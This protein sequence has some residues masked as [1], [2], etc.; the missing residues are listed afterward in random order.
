VAVLIP[1]SAFIALIGLNMINLPAF[2]KISFFKPVFVFA[3]VILVIRSSFAQWYFPFKPYNEEYVIKQI[4]TYIQTTRPNFKKVC[5]IHPSLPV[6]ADLDPYDNKRVELLHTTDLEHI[7]QLPDSTLLLW[8]SHFMK[9]DGKIPFNWLSENPNFIMLKHY[10]FS[11]EELPF[12]A[13][14]FIRAANPM[15]VP[16]PV[17]LV[18]PSGLILGNQTLETQI[19]TFE[20]DTLDFN[21]WLNLRTSFTGRNAV[22]FTP[23]MEF[24]P[25]FRK[26]IRDINKH[27]NLKSATLKFNLNQADTITDFVSV[28][29]IKDNKKQVYW[30]GLIINQSLQANQWNAIELRHTFSE[31][32]KNDDLMVNIYIWNKGKRNFYIDDFQIAFESIPN[33]D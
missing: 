24:G 14:L 15:P 31:P 22:A 8:E 5:F 6:L 3:V 26:K 17:E 11:N 30:K 4:A 25:V 1:S 27:K 32:I 18:Y 7:N 33:G 9:V 13:C 21:K 29:E 2:T 28:V 16:V 12:E 23:E 19:Y 20:N 10:R